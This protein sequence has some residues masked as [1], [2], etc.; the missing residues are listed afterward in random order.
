MIDGQSVEGHAGDDGRREHGGRDRVAPR[1][2]FRRT[3][4]PS[5]HE[6][7]E[8]EEGVVRGCARAQQA[9]ADGKG[10]ASHSLARPAP[11]CRRRLSR[12]LPERWALSADPD[13]HQDRERHLIKRIEKDVP[14]ALD[15]AARKKRIQQPARRR[16]APADAEPAEYRHR[17]HRDQGKSGEKIQ[18][19]QKRPVA[20]EDRHQLDRQQMKALV[21]QVGVVVE[22]EAGGRGQVRV[23]PEPAVVHDRF[24]GARV[25][26]S[27]APVFE[28]RVQ[29]RFG[30]LEQ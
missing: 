7:T 26:E 20:A 9:N 23:G 1:P 19:Q 10:R 22:L 3:P 16:R 4:D 28:R 6:Q 5:D 30:K 25:V 21:R 27:V 17:R 12:R 14:L 18:V 29:I 11:V 8:R 15:E 13:Q 24:D 2:V